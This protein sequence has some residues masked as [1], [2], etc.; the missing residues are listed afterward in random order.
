MPSKTVVDEQ[1]QTSPWRWS[2][3]LFPRAACAFQDHGPDPV[4]AASRSF[5]WSRRQRSAPKR[6]EACASAVTARHPRIRI[7]CPESGRAWWDA[8]QSSAMGLLM[9]PGVSSVASRNC[10]VKHYSNDTARPRPAQATT[11]HILSTQNPPS[12][13]HRPET[14]EP[15]QR[16]GSVPRPKIEHD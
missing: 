5:G 11:A 6:S 8:P 16:P 1:V 15:G 12:Y 14:A 9:K 10:A 2:G 3:F 13:A 4:S 7:T